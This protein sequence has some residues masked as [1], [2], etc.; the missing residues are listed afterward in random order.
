MNPNKERVEELIKL[1]RDPSGEVGPPCQRGVRAFRR[2][3]GDPAKLPEEVAHYGLAV[4]SPHLTD[5][6]LDLCTSVAPCLAC[7][8]TFVERLTPLRFARILRNAP[9]S[10]FLEPRYL[11]YDR[12]SPLKMRI[13]NRH[14]ER[15]A[16]NPPEWKWK[17]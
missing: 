17:P 4:M 6:E 9:Y 5:A 2:W 13:V 7:A 10:Y 15:R 8:S 11:P 12:L 14:L 1:A 16:A 3:K